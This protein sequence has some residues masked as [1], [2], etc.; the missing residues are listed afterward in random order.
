MTTDSLWFLDTLV[1]VRVSW[2]ENADHISVLEHRAPAGDSPP[3][4]VHHTEDEVF[5]ILEGALRLHV[6]GEDR[7]VGAGQVLLAPKG[8]AHTYRVESPDGARWLTVTAQRD[9]ENFVRAMARPAPRPELPPPSGPPTPEAAEA[10]ME[11]ARR[12]GIEIVGPP[13]G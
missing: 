9:F 8:I 4:H 13:L 10:L 3:L 7:T 5:C 6:G 12:F 2:A 1:T 11:T